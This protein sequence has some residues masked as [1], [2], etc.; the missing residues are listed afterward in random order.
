MGSATTMP[1]NY[2][3][4]QFDRKW[5]PVKYAICFATLAH[6][7]LGFGFKSDTRVNHDAH[8]STGNKGLWSM[9]T[10]IGHPLICHRVTEFGLV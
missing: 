10:R 5:T 2:A 3:A 7:S 4:Q 9:L 8:S 1:P 6:F